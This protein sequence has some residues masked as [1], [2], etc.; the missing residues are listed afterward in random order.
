MVV[1]YAYPENYCVGRLL[2][3]SISS[4]SFDSFSMVCTGTIPTELA[5]LTA[6]AHLYLHQTGLKVNA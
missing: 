4:D 1:V 6:L 5:K 3:C 2:S